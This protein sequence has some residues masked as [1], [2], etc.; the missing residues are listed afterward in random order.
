MR[1]SV[2]KAWFPFCFSYS[3]FTDLCPAQHLPFCNLSFDLILTCT[4]IYFEVHTVIV[5]K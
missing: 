1:L 2:F 3:S 5:L 4:C